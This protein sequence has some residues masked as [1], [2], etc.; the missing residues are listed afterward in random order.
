MCLRC[1]LLVPGVEIEL[2]I[3]LEIGLEL[4]CGESRYG[5]VDAKLVV[6]LVQCG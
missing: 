1:V 2:E 5:L 4:R 6:E 3:E